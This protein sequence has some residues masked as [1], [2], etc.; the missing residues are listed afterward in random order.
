M[1][2]MFNLTKEEERIFKK[3]DTPSKIQDFLNAIPFNYE[4]DGVDTW[5]SPRR[6]LRD[7]KAH[8]VE[9]ALFA[10]AAL[11]YHG[12]KPLLMGFRTAPKDQDHFVALYRTNGYWGSISKTN[13]SILRFR[14]PVYQTPRELAMSHFHEYFM[15]ET[16]VKT[17]RDYSVPFDLSRLGKGWVTTEEELFEIVDRVNDSRHLPVI[18][19]KNRRQ[20]RK[21]EPV[22]ITMG[23]ILE[24]DKNDPRT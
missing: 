14:D 24:W 19:A 8:C 3:L 12:K 13:H 11:W 2:S 4:R 9:G 5:R 1:Y 10:A 16:G 23:K 15:F 21:A 6:V 7:K 17:L 18:P 20:I 22:E